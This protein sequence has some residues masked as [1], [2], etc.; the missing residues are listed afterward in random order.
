PCRNPAQIGRNRCTPP[1]LPSGRCNFAPA[2]TA[3]TD[4]R[5]GR[6]RLPF[7]NPDP[8]QAMDLSRDSL[9]SAI[10]LNAPCISAW[11]ARARKE[12][13]LGVSSDNAF[14]STRRMRAALPNARQRVLQSR[15]RLRAWCR[16]D[17]PAARSD[18]KQLMLV[19]SP[20]ASTKPVL[21]PDDVRLV[22]E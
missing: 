1:R 4:I 3:W 14:Q 11:P 19:S 7:S 21:Q 5:T 2:L 15:R 12:L 22:L 13:D 9:R 18:Q 16:R 20:V 17:G 8:T 10:D 6:T